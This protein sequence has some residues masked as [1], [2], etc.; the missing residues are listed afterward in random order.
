MNAFTARDKAKRIGI[1]CINAVNFA[2][3]GSRPDDYSH[4]RFSLD[5]QILE[6]RADRRLARFG[7]LVL[8]IGGAGSSGCRGGAG[9]ARAGIPAGK[10]GGHLTGGSAGDAAT[11]GFSRR[12]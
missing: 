11:W 6:G 8:L 9:R 3:S 10:P 2:L 4:P 5:E 7:L 1:L 12:R